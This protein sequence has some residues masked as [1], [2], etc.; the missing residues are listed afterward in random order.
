MAGTVQLHH[1]AGTVLTPAVTRSIIILLTPVALRF[2]APHHIASSKTEVVGFEISA[3]D[4]DGR[5]VET[6]ASTLNWLVLDA[7]PGCEWRG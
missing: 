5:L 3:V 2:S 4:S 6:D 1:G 7:L